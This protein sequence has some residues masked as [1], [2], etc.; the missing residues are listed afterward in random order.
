[1]TSFSPEGCAQPATRWITPLSEKPAADWSAC[2]GR[3]LKI[4]FTRPYNRF[5]EKVKN[6]KADV[7]AVLVMHRTL[8]A[9]VLN[10]VKGVRQDVHLDP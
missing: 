2:F 10:S 3:C 6:V 9:E 1:M 8:P 7:A 4:Q 5:Y